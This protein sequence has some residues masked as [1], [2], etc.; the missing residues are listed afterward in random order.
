VAGLAS[1][2]S[3]R[4]VAS[5]EE[6]TR[7]IFEETE[8]RA[9]ETELV[10]WLAAGCIPAGTDATLTEVFSFDKACLFLHALNYLKFK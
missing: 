4:E 3:S 5:S 7:R 6:E 9:R 2:N 1:N 8:R 10:A